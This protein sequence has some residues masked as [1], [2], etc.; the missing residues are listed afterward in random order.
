MS[1]LTIIQDVADE[2]G[3]ARPTAVIGNSNPETR[4]FLRYAQKVGR[5]ILKSFP[6][7]IL[8]KEQTFTSLATETQTSIL[9]SDFDRICP[10]SFWNRTDNHL[11]IGPI[12]PVEWNSLKA[13]SYD[14]DTR[15]KFIIRGDVLMAIP[16][17]TA[18][19]SLA[20]EY[21]SKNWCQSSASAEQ[22][23]WVADDDTGILDEELMTRAIIFEFLW[24][25]GLPADVAYESYDNYCKMLMDNDQPDGDILV[26]GDIFMGGR[27]HT[28]TPSASGASQLF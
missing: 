22:S 6:W 13:N 7:Q 26:A 24:G 2:V 1:L 28:G 23:K 25:D 10:E 21:V 12:T 11:M 19:K 15:H 16:V 20:F 27:H 8:R 14:D 9:P 4:K 17:M 3:I 18:G 5:S